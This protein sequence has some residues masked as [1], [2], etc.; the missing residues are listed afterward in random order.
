MRLD[1]SCAEE[2]RFDLYQNRMLTYWATVAMMAVRDVVSYSWGLLHGTEA[3]IATSC[4]LTQMIW[5]S[6]SS[7]TSRNLVK[8]APMLSHTI[9]IDAAARIYQMLADRNPDLFGVI[10]D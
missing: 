7:Y 4:H 9:L 8:I 2:L 3:R 5:E 6:P 10:F 1:C